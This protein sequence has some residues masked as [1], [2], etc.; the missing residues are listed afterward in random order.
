M[1]EPAELSI[2]DWVQSFSDWLWGPPMLVL[3]LGTGL[4]LLARLRV[5]QL[6]R[7][8]DA[9]QA[10][11]HKISGDGDITPFAALMTAVSG[12]V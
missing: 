1:P 11:R 4:Y 12:I 3:V 6:R 2:A 10:L 9:V 7:F 5:V 8:R